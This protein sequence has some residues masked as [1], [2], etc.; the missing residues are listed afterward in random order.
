MD[1]DVCVHWLCFILLRDG[2]GEIQRFECWMDIK[3][4]VSFLGSSCFTGSFPYRAL[5]PSV[6]MMLHN[7]GLVLDK[8]EMSFFFRYSEGGL[9][10][11]VSGVGPEASWSEEPW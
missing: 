7:G 9:L 2:V 4:I 5:L 6:F 8:R 1:V 11:I 3:L 10:M